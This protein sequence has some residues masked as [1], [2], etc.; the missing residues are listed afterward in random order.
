MEFRIASSFTASLARLTNSEQKLTKTTIFDL[1]VNPESPGLSFHKLDRARDSG[2]W[3]VRVSRDIRLIV[4]RTDSSVL[5]CYVGHHDAAYGWAE[6]RKLERHPRTGAAQFVEIRETVREVEVPVYVETTVAEPR[7]TPVQ[8]PL[9]FDGLPTE[10]LLA[11]GVPKEWLQDVQAATEDSLLTLA[12]HLPEEAAEALLELATGGEPQVPVQISAETDAFRHPDALRRFR[13]VESVEELE[14]ALEYPWEKWAVFLHPSQRDTVECKYSGPA[15][16]FG[17]AGTGKTVVALHRA[18][19]LARE[20]TSSSVLLTTFSIPLARNLRRKLRSLVSEDDAVGQQISVRSIDEAGIDLYEE[21]VGSPAVVTLPKL[22]VLLRSPAEQ[23]PDRSF[24][25]R[26]LE[27]EWTEVVDA[28]QLRSWEE[29]RD[30]PRLGR[31]TRLGEEQRLRLWSIFEQVWT[32]LSDE[33]LVTM[34]MVFAAITE[35]LSEGREPPYHFVVVDEAQDISVPQL[36]FLAALAGDKPDGLFFAGD[37]GQ[38]IFRTPFSW[39]ALGVDLGT[40]S[41]TLKVN[42]RTTHQIRQQSDR[43]LSSVLADVDGIKEDRSRTVS[44][45]NGPAPTVSVYANEEAEAVA[46]G[47]WLKRVLTNGIAPRECAVFV[48]SDLEIDRAKRAVQ[49]AGHKPTIPRAGEDIPVGS[50]PVMPMHSAKGLEFRAVAVMACDDE[51]IPLQERIEQ[52]ADAA[53]LEDVYNTERS[54][55]YVAC[56]RARDHLM[57]SGVEPASEFL[58]DLSE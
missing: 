48:R 42:Y 6:R 37:L 33:A 22:R 19:H 54:L 3:S 49:A 55:L 8:K 43:L 26:F 46:V 21:W 16:V 7:P 57:I 12:D 25:D 13:V 4:H 5:V 17:S 52:V 56:T 39:R 47:E 53:D 30:V 1:Q 29:Y 9:L 18:V 35:E 51:V 20:H 15:R 23:I 31:K 28:W 41:R 32:R 58:D 40:R 27:G 45:F 34:P 44:V 50:V 11:Y 10:D 38:R 2:F 14:R 24:A 36:R